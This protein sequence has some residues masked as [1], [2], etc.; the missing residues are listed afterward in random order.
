MRFLLDAE[1]KNKIL[2]KRTVRRCVEALNTRWIALSHFLRWLREKED[3]EFP[4]QKNEKFLKKIVRLYVEKIT[5]YWTYGDNDK[6][7]KTEVNQKVEQIIGARES[8]TEIEMIIEL[9]VLMN[10]SR[11]EIDEVIRWDITKRII[12]ISD[13]EIS[14]P[15]TY[16]FFKKLGK[17]IKPEENPKI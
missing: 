1:R 11:K 10:L 5:G 8:N 3:G 13:T 4:E 15:K 6:D 9:L 14:D 2:R 17:Q 16:Q 12:Q 7:Y